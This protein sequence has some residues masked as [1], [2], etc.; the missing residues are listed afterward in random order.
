MFKRGQFFG[1]RLL[2]RSLVI[3]SLLLS[4]RVLQVPLA[5]LA[6]QGPL[7]LLDLRAALDLREFEDNR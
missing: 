4:D 6:Y 1:V 5:L 3:I 7:D 2:S